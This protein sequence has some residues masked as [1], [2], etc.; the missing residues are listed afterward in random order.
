MLSSA[1]LHGTGQHTSK[2]HG[3]CSQLP[4]CASRLSITGALDF[5]SSSQLKAVLRFHLGNRER[6]RNMWELKTRRADI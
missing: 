3:S 1:G 4:P 6:N 2:R 5:Q